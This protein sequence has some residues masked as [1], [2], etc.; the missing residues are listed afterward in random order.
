MLDSVLKNYDKRVRPNYGG[1]PV[2]VGITMLILGISSV[3]EVDMDFTMDFY[4]RQFWTDE[5]LAVSSPQWDNRLSIGSEVIDKIWIP[6]TFFANEKKAYFHMATTANSFLRI[7]SDGGI[8]RSMRLT[9]TG[10]CFMNLRH[11]PMDGQRCSL[12]IESFGYTAKDVVYKWLKGK[13]SMAI[14]HD[15]E[16]SQFNLLGHRILSKEI[17]LST[18]NYSR[19]ACEFFFVRDMG[20]YLIQLYIPSGLIVII[21]WVSFWLNRNASPARVSLGVTTV[22]TMTTLMTS[23]N[24]ALPKVSY[25][26]SIDIY[27]G[28]CFVLVFAALL[29]YAAVGYL[30][31][32]L[33]LVDRNGQPRFGVE[34]D[35]PEQSI[36][37]KDYIISP[38][39]IDKYSRIAFPVFFFGFNLL[40]WI[41][42]LQ[43]NESVIGDIT[44]LA[45]E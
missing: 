16:L 22:L 1:P 33:E 14:S 10:A 44:P 38:G 17:H 13:A 4:F 32:H 7:G 41:I 45:S 6:D 39:D 36:S 25:V 30:A 26:K 43:I 18:G 9:V 42:Y 19:L 27:L 11:F 24:A 34:Q 12:E 23:T 21:S 5:R 37:F 15:V 35:F 8:I 40:Y 28:T 20:Y 2:E 29:E 31:K 3:S